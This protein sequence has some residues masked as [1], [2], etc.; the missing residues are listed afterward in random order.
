MVIM[1]K[2]KLIL[3]LIIVT[4]TIFVIS[5]EA[6]IAHVFN[7]N[8]KNVEHLV[9]ERPLLSKVYYFVAYI[10]FTAFSL[11][12]AGLMGLLGGM[13]FD[14]IDAVIIVSFAS[15]IGALLSFWL[16][17][18]LLRDYLK[19]KYSHYYLLINKGFTK[20]GGSYLFA[21][22]MCMIFPYFIIN[23][24]AGLTTIKSWL[25]YIISQIGMLPG[26]IIII[27]LGSKLEESLTTGINID[28]MTI[29]ILTALG[30]L[31]IISRYYFK[32]YI[33]K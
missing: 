25:Y 27:I 11:P 14:V 28:L 19:N 16:S 6:N 3:L 17:R 31:P 18:Y 13:I 10:I 15:S 29:F 26:T 22:R 2:F 20:N 21:I 8:L 23:S 33:K 5:I 24:L 9:I 4:S 12:V 32:S 1:N 30:I 7:N